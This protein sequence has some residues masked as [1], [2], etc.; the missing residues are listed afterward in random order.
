MKT[1]TVLSFVKLLHDLKKQGIIQDNFEIWIS[2]DEEGNSFSP[3]VD[4]SEISVGVEGKR[5]I[6]YPSSHQSVTE[7]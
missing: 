4:E 3:L 7:L 6:L 5:I 1:L 2:Q